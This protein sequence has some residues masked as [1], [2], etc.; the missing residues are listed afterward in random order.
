ML[1][2]VHS[3]VVTSLEGLESLR[4][5]EMCAQWISWD[6]DVGMYDLSYTHCSLLAYSY[7]TV[8]RD[9]C[10]W[11]LVVISIWHLQ[12]SYVM[13]FED[14]AL[15]RVNF[16]W[17][18]WATDL[19]PV[20]HCWACWSIFIKSG[21]LFYAVMSFQNLHIMHNCM[22]MSCGDHHVMLQVNRSQNGSGRNADFT[23]CN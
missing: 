23:S 17:S 22:G 20:L 6:T 4:K 21:H 10:S 15:F 8:M 14:V 5:K 7:T 9:S 12:I 11:L 18:E 19:D 16:C 2:V 13:N 3:S 1:S